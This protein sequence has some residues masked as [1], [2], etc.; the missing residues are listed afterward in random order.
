MSVMRN[1]ERGCV[2]GCGEVEGLASR[3]A[4]WIVVSFGLVSF[5]VSGAIVHVTDLILRVAVLCFRLCFT[6]GSSVL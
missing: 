3:E 6:N 2:G 4:V 5:G 1:F